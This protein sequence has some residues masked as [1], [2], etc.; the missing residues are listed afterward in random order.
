MKKAVLAMALLVYVVST[1][2]RKNNLEPLSEAVG[3]SSSISAEK[4]LGRPQPDCLCP[5]VYD[6]VCGCNGVTYS[7]SC[8]AFC[9]GVLQ[10]TPGPCGCLGKPQPDCLCPDVYDPVCGCNGVTYSNSC[11]AFCAGV[12]QYTAGACNLG[13][14]SGKKQGLAVR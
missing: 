9:A 7:N 8:G 11:A 4:C 5:D 12:L 3:L 14:E 10:Y 13:W 6:P 1:G 2:C